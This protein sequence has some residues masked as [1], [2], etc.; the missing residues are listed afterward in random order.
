MPA[1]GGAAAAAARGGQ[2][3][4]GAAAHMLYYVRE[5]SPD[6]G[7]VMMVAR[8]LH[9]KMEPTLHVIGGLD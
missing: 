6:R 1:P 3:S 4:Q 9:E 2:V 7:E 8:M 5:R